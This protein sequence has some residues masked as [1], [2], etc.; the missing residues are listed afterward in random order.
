MKPLA[1]LALAALAA[2]LPANSRA[3]PPAIDAGGRELRYVVFLRPDPGRKPLPLEERQR[4]QDAHMANIQKIADDGVLVAAGPMEDRPVTI[5]GIF[6]FKTPSLSEARR[7]AALDPTVARGRN[8]VDVHS[9]RGP[10]GIGAA[11]FRWR[12][13]HPDAKDVMASHALCLTLRGPAWAGGAQPDAEHEKF[14]ASL[15]AAGLLAAA[16]PVE[17]DP[18]LVGIV[19]FKTPSTQEARK[20]LEQDPAVRAG[21]IAIEYHEWWT[22]DGVLPW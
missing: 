9:W 8:T 13:Q 10:A 16:G 20:A 3:D 1:T 21:R 14:V 19:V 17:D 15:R 12:K 11:Y 22:A 7:I 5:S 6:V 4:I 18:D 2:G